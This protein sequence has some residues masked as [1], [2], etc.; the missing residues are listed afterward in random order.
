[1]QQ[2]V[3]LAMFA[4]L[5][6]SNI[7]AS[8]PANENVLHPNIVRAMDDADANTQIEFIVQ[9]RPELTNQ[10]LQ[11]AEGIGIEVISIFEFIDGFFG[12]ATA[13]QIRDLSK[14]DDIFWIEHNSQMEYYMQD[15]TRV[16]NAVETWQ[17][18]I[19]NEDE[20]VIADQADQHTVSYTH[21][22]LPTNREV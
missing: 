22:T 18:V 2:K 10:H 7:G 3:A 16:I 11:T 21:L 17:T 15:T 13:S 1:M 4:I 8:A 5:L 14:Q 12:K 20:Q 19:I 9:Y 6:I